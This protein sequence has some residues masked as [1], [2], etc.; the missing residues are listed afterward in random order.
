VNIFLVPYTW[1]RH[2]S[3]AF[4]CAAAGLFAWWAVLTLVVVGPQVSLAFDWPPGADGPLLVGTIAAFVAGASVLGEGNLR[5]QP[6]LGRIF[7]VALAVLITELIAQVWY[8][9]WH[10]IVPA[11]LFSSPARAEDAGDSSLVSLTYRLGAFAMAGAGTGMGPL[12]VRKGA[13]WIAHLTGGMAAGLGGAL[14]WHLLGYSN[15][16]TDLYLPGAALGLVWGFLFGLLSWGIP[17][18]LYAGWLRVLSPGRYGRRIPIDAPA[19]GPK[20]RFIGHFPRGLDLFLPVEN[21]VLELHLSIAVDKQQRYAARGLTLSPTIVRRFLERIDLRY[22]PRR[23]APLETPLS[24]G[25][26]IQLGT[27][28][29]SAELEFILLPREES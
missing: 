23:P 28:A 6:L 11:L 16:N 26:R 4:W 3:M 15:L 27:G 29:N 18:E 8:Q 12:I 17:D 19:G 1:M 9:L 14:V 5:R 7:R 21:G 2:L 10:L 13:G 20:E 22:D 24:S 25:D